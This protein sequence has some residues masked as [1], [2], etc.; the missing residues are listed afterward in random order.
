MAHFVYHFISN[1]L[2]CVDIFLIQI[3]DDESNDAY[4]T[5]LED[6]E[7]QSTNPSTPLEVLI[8]S[9]SYS[10]TSACL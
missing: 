3:I 9:H 7:E 4:A 1:I 2:I 6:F 10:G 8:I 5:L